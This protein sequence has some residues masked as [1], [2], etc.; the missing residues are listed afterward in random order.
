M[1][2]MSYEDYES[3]LETLAVQSDKELVKR[4]KKADQDLKNGKGNSLD[5]IHKD[6]KIV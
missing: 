2:M 1:V 3:L 5:K 4:V 6:L